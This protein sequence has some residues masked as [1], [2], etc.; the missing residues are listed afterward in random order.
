MNYFESLPPGHQP[1][2]YLGVSERELLRN[3][4]DDVISVYGKASEDQDEASAYFTIDPGEIDFDGTKTWPNQDVLESIEVACSVFPQAEPQEYQLFVTRIY[5]QEVFGSL[6]NQL[7]ISSYY[8]V[9]EDTESDSYSEVRTFLTAKDELFPAD[10]AD[11]ETLYDD[12][13]NQLSGEEQSTLSP[14]ALDSY[15]DGEGG[16]SPITTNQLE[17]IA[18]IF[19][20][21]DEAHHAAYEEAEDG[22]TDA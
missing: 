8:T 11:Y 10:P 15:Y 20:L 5:R 12:K 14:E 1:P 2:E 6:G 7:I 22:D 16:N 3:S 4:I 17:E 9:D 21:L 18:Q 13:K 19:G